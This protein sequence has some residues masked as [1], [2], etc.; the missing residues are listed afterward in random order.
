ML[1]RRSEAALPAKYGGFVKGLDRTP[2]LRHNKENLVFEVFYVKC[3]EITIANRI[4]L[5]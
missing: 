3:G 2:V 5:G 1:A 4:W